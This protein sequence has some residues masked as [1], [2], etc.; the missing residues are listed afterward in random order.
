MALLEHVAVKTEDEMSKMELRRLG[1][2]EAAK[3]FSSK[4][5]NIA[6]E[7]MTTFD[8]TEELSQVTNFFSYGSAKRFAPS[9]E[10]KSEVEESAC[11]SPK[12]RARSFR[13]SPP[14]KPGTSDNHA[15]W[16]AEQTSH[17]GDVSK[18]SGLHANRV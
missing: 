9:S 6:E 13:A 7:A 12:N 1:L 4:S 15:K 14:T 8:L 18:S 17:D 2:P 5:S 11:T 16:L 10:R 3:P